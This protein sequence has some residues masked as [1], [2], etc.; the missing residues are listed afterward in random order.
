MLTWAVFA[1]ADDLDTSLAKDMASA[2]PE[3]AE[4][5]DKENMHLKDLT[6]TPFNQAPTKARSARRPKLTPINFGSPE[7]RDMPAAEEMHDLSPV[8]PAEPQQEAASGPEAPTPHSDHKLPKR[9]SLFDVLGKPAAKKAKIQRGKER[10][11]KELAVEMPP[12]AAEGLATMD[13]DEVRLNP[14][15]SYACCIPKPRHT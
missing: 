5:M 11:L 14:F 3:A 2:T 1:A 12:E 10:I 15:V 9:Q 7:A 6:P 8:T 13:S 4:D